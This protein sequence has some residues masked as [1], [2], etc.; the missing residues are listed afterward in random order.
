MFSEKLKQLRE[1]NNMTQDDLAKLLHVSRS[2]IAGYETKGKNPDYEKLRWLCNYFNVTSDFFL[3]ITPNNKS[4]TT[5]IITL[6]DDE[7]EELNY[8]R[9][10]SKEH[11]ILILAQMIKYIQ[12]QDNFNAQEKDIG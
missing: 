11:K 12:E 2:T 8:Y 7:S 3:D 6:P 1:K 5:K 4:E 10:L 9:K